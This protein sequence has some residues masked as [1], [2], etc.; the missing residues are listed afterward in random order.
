MIYD[1]G[2]I[3]SVFTC[4]GASAGSLS[5]TLLLSNIDFIKASEVALRLGV[6]ADVYKR[7][8]GL[9]GIWGSLLNTFLNEIIPDDV[10]PENYKNLQIAVTPYLTKPKL[11]TG[12]NSKSE[13]IEACLASCHIPVFLDG[14]PS[15]TFRGEQVRD[16][17]YVYL[18]I[19]ISFYMFKCLNKSHL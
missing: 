6:E 2:Q 16:N 13:V 10:P 18:Y 1:N 7:K 17:K 9:A 15:T 5:A 19:F 3:N 8:A 4:L 12:F 14:R 11:V